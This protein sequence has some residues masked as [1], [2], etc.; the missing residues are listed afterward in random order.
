MEK[1]DLEDSNYLDEGL[2]YLAR[3]IARQIYEKRRRVEL[4]QVISVEG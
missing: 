4:K 1:L 2:G 3:I